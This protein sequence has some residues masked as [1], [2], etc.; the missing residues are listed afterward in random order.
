MYHVLMIEFLKH[1]F[2]PRPQLGP[3]AIQSAFREHYRNFRA[4][5][6]ANN[7]AL[8]LMSSVKDMLN[9]GKPFGMAFV[10][11]DLTALT[12]NVY[13]M[14]HSLIA[15]SDGTTRTSMSVSR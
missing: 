14:V 15:L 12:V 2:R 6:T 8:D 4:L 7:N 5:L 3:E 1:L 13:K 10:R 9:S 11:G